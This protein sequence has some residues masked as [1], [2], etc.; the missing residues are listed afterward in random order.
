MKS[1]F[2]EKIHRFIYIFALILLVA[3]LPLS[4]FLMSLSQI[5]LLCNWVLEGDLKNKFRSFLGNKTALLLSS[6]LLLH[7]LGLFYTSDFGYAFKDIR[8]KL[9]LLLMPLII[10]TSKPLSQK[11]V[12]IIL[13]LFI[14]AVIAGTIISMLILG[15]VIYRPVVDTRAISIFISH[16]RFALLICVAAC[17]SIYFIFNASRFSHK[18]LWSA[19][20]LWLVSFLIILESLTGLITLTLVLFVL[21][22][23]I[24]IKSEIRILKYGSLL[25]LI[26]AVCFPMYYVKSIANEKADKETIKSKKLDVYTSR[27]NLYE[28]DRSSSLTENGYLIWV[29]YCSTEIEEVW[30]QRSEIKIGKQDLK[31]NN[32]GFTLVRFLT[33]KGLKKDAD[34][35]M[36]LT[37]E[38]VKAIERGV[39]NVDYQKISSL[40]GRIHETIWEIDLYRTTG[41]ANG[42]SL[43][44]R[45]EY[46]K[47]AIGII[48]NNFLLGVGTGDLPNAFEQEYINNN[49]TL[50][51]EWRLRSHNQYLSIAAAFGIVGLIWFLVTLIFPLLIKNNRLNFLHITFFIIATISFFTEDTLETQA[52]VTFYAFF[53]SFFLFVA[54]SNAYILSPKNKISPEAD[55]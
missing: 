37:N 44:Q 17:V 55:V 47:A 42:H 4:K 39:A 13:K 45:F 15:K 9:P 1:L 18:F 49:S 8:I 23:Y 3:G 11:L 21:L 40:K 26:G 32:V 19:V 54:N 30:N 35:V 28:H 2:P 52:G 12:D 25:F 22:I 31:G 10:S 24:V 5:I 41:D 14:A 38:E 46:W 36:S 53:N 20:F 51:K 16:I 50:S 33:S 7:F 43:T 48:N 34:A 29:N 27:G 6:L